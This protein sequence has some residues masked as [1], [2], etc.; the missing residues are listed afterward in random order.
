MLGIVGTVALA[1][2]LVMH[3]VLFNLQ[4]DGLARLAADGFGGV[5]FVVGRC[6]VGPALRV[7]AVGAA[8][9]EVGRLGDGQH[10]DIVLT[11]ILMREK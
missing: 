7:E 4:A 11:F 8:D 1:G 2:K 10:S 5:G 6:R 9:E 3:P